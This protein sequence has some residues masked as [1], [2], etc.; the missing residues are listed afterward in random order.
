MLDFI[1]SLPTP[2]VIVGAVIIYILI[3]M[4]VSFIAGLIDDGDEALIAI[5]ALW[6][7]A[8]P[9]A[10]IMGMLWLFVAPF[11]FG[12]KLSKPKI[13]D[14]PFIMSDDNYEEEQ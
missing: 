3:G 7:I 12:A 6:I 8:I 13:S 4:I 9:M 11:R 14:E 10:A 1:K 5:G 2:V